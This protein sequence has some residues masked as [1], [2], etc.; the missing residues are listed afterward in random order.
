MLETGGLQVNEILKHKNARDLT[1]W[2]YSGSGSQSAQQPYEHSSS[3]S[4]H[5]P[6]SCYELLNCIWVRQRE[7]IR[8]S[9]V[10]NNMCQELGQPRH[11]SRPSQDICFA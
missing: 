9:T 2:Q 5:F 1:W 3:S 4:Q 11:P 10:L 8:D 7:C 6:S